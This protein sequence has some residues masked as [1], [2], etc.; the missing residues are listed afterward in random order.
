[1]VNTM[2]DEPIKETHKEFVI[3]DKPKEIKDEIPKI[4]QSDLPR[5]EGD[6]GKEYPS[7]VGKSKFNKIFAVTTISFLFILLMVFGTWFM[8]S[9]GDYTKKE[10]MINVNTPAVS[11]TINVS[12]TINVPQTNSTIIVNVDFSE[13]LNKTIK[14]VVKETLNQLNLTNSSG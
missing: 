9:F 4:P 12:S 2:S 1:M 8:F 7:P 10:S 11:P 5:R 3:K 13:E 14:S 6:F